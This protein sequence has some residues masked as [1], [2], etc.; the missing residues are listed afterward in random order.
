MNL[1]SRYDVFILDEFWAV[2][3][4]PEDLYNAMTENLQSK[5]KPVQLNDCVWL[6]DPVHLREEMVQTANQNCFAEDPS[7]VPLD[8]WLPL[9]S[10]D[11]RDNLQKY[12]V[13][14]NMSEVPLHERPLRVVALSQDPT[15]MPMMSTDAGVCCAFTASSTSR[16]MLTNQ[17]RWMTAREK[18]A[19]CGF[20]VHEDWI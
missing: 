2:V 15:H 4:K 20:P 18:A 19:M 8:D 16:L 13:K 7:T 9:L 10:K 11:E 12:L 3:D 14:L 1:P 6:D 5:L 17:N